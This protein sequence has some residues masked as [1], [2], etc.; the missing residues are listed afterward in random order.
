MV[1]VLA[2]GGDP[3]PIFDPD[4]RFPDPRDVLLVCPGLVISVNILG[5]GTTVTHM[6][7]R[8]A[9]FSIQEYLISSRVSSDIAIFKVDT[10]AAN[11]TIAIDCLCHL[12][13]FHDSNHKYYQ[14]LTKS[15]PQQT[16]IPK[17]HFNLDVARIYFPDQHPLWD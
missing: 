15:D 9:H 13:Y 7:L 4:A 12:L 1:D 17:A 6:E 2:V 16:V 11:N 14:D 8:L 5:Y 3:N 10:I